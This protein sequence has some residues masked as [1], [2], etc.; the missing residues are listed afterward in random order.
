MLG[1]NTAL[2]IPLEAYGCVFIIATTYPEACVACVREEKN[3][4]GFHF[5]GKLLHLLPPNL[6]LLVSEYFVAGTLSVPR[7]FYGVSFIRVAKLLRRGALMR[8]SWVFS[9]FCPLDVVFVPPESQHKRPV[10]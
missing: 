10:K 5:S 8:S 3:F 4:C 6:M 9:S 1:R 2:S 7:R